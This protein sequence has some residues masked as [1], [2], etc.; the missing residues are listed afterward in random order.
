MKRL[1]LVRTLKGTIL[2]LA[3]M[4]AVPEGLVQKEEPQVFGGPAGPQAGPPAPA[5]LAAMAVPA[6]PAGK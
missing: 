4:A 3:A 6:A 2:F 1:G 5:V